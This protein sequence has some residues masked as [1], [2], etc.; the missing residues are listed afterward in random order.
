MLQRKNDYDFDSA[1]GLFERDFS[2]HSSGDF[3]RGITTGV[4]CHF[5][6]NTKTIYWTKYECLVLSTELIAFDVEI[7][8]S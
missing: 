6:E 4:L 3:E 5:C 2:G 1:K 8:H 7:T